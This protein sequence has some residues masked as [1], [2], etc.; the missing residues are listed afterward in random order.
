MLIWRESKT[1]GGQAKTVL[2]HTGSTL[3][4]TGYCSPPNWLYLNQLLFC[5]FS[6]TFG[7]VLKGVRKQNHQLQDWYVSS[8]HKATQRQ[9]TGCFAINWK[10]SSPQPRLS[11]LAG[12]CV[13]TLSDWR[14]FCRN[15]DVWRCKR[16]SSD[17]GGEQW[18]QWA[19][20]CPLLLGLLQ[21]HCLQRCF[22][23]LHLDPK[24]H[25]HY[26]RVVSTVFM[27][28]EFHLHA[29]SDNTAIFYYSIMFCS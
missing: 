14:L 8:E 18:G 25:K 11:G 15:P 5:L 4:W 1:R 2:Y 21:M 23:T 19:M 29:C 3:Y 10:N 27:C 28:L 20:G 7:F 22:T 16:Q 9:A 12:G 17:C 24:K 13:K 26:M 6:L